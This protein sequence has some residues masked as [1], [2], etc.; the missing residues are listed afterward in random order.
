MPIRYEFHITTP[1]NTDGFKVSVDMNIINQL[2]ARNH[3]KR[4]FPMAT[5]ISLIRSNRIK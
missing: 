1:E 2:A 4:L 5:Q 3:I